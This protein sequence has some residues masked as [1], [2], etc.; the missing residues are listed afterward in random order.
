MGLAPI[1]YIASE[2]QS[3]Q[4][5]RAHPIPGKNR[6]VYFERPLSLSLL[7]CLSTLTRIG[8]PSELPKPVRSHSKPY[9]DSSR[10]EIEIFGTLSE[11]LFSDP[12]Q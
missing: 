12:L 5:S 9:A 2:C 3:K 1:L 8:A 10:D 4:L 7:P 6:R 11:K